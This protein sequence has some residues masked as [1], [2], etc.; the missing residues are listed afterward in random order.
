MRRSVVSAPPCDDSRQRAA[1]QR[2]PCIMNT[3]TQA[4][5]GPYEQAYQLA[6]QEVCGRRR[7]TRNFRDAALWVLEQCRH[8][9]AV[10]SLLDAARSVD[11]SER[12]MREYVRRLQYMGLIDIE[13][14]ATG[15][16]SRYTLVCR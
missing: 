15:G 5:P 16:L 7:Y 13:Y 12:S 11:V 14:S 2:C 10:F 9:P 1:R 8:G 6:V 3:I 4:P